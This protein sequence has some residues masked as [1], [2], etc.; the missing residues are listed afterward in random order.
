V[1]S[2]VETT[3]FGPFAIPGFG[4]ELSSWMA[5]ELYSVQGIAGYLMLGRSSGE[6]SRDD[7]IAL[8]S[9]ARTIA[10]IVGARIE[11]EKADFIRKQVEASLA[12][13]ERRLRS[14]FEDSRDMIYTANA[15]DIVTAI[16]AA[17]QTLTGRKGPR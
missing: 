2:G 3:R 14:F 13:S 16:N 5:S 12:A 6:W 8:S 9:I 1:K 17:G 7:G 11:R 10:P 15:D 4:E